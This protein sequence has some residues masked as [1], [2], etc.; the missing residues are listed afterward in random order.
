[1]NLLTS[2]RLLRG[3]TLIFDQM[4]PKITTF[5]IREEACF[6]QFI[7]LLRGLF[8]HLIHHLAFDEKAA[9]YYEYAILIHYSSVANLRRY[10]PELILIHLSLL[11]RS[12][13][14]QFLHRY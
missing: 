7:L 2:I 1:M 9:N 14:N 11:R 5:K 10:L 13:S 12:H 6:N 8:R 4:T 3:Y